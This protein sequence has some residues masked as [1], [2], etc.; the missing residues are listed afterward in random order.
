MLFRSGTIAIGQTL[1]DASGDI[2]PGT[3][4]VSGS[5]SSWQVSTSQTVASE[6]MFG[7]LANQ[8]DQAVQINQVPTL[9]AADIV[10]TL[11]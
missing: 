3:T 2:L 8:N 9:P 11:T 5:G 1:T 10:V 7:V 6:T 4:I